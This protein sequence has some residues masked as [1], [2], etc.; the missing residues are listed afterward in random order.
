ML[1]FRVAGGP[2]DGS[3][4]GDNVDFNGDPGSDFGV[5]TDCT[6]DCNTVVD[7]VVSEGVPLDATVN[8]IGFDTRES[9]TFDHHPNDN[10]NNNKINSLVL[11][12]GKLQTTGIHMTNS[13]FLY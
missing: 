3:K 9:V 11:L 4:V 12:E 5:E 13:C 6:L 2:T 7:I 8:N 10:N 1:G